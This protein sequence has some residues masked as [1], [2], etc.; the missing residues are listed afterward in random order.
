VTI[1]RRQGVKFTF[2]P[3]RR[4]EHYKRQVEVKG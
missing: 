2:S 1:G 3:P 4:L